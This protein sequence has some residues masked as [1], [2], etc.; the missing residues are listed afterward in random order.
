MGFI[1]FTQGLSYDCLVELLGDLI[2]GVL[3]ILAFISALWVPRGRLRP[4]LAALF[5]VLTVGAIG[6]GRFA[7]SQAAHALQKQQNNLRPRR[8]PITTGF[9]FGLIE[10]NNFTIV[11]G[12]ISRDQIAVHSFTGTP[13]TLRV[14]RDGAVLLDGDIRG[15]DGSVV[16]EIRDSRIVTPGAKCDVNSD[17]SALEIVD[18]DS[19]PVIQLFR[20]GRA[21]QFNCATYDV[22]GQGLLVCSPQVGC[23]PGPVSEIE[24]F[25]K[26]LTPIFLYPGYKHI[27]VRRPAEHV[28]TQQPPPLMPTPK[29]SP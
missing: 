13:L 26:T 21:I 5:A 23:R 24:P 18:E 28:K 2:I 4:V 17:E 1:Q 15:R 3:G 19:R 25:R 7:S 12:P 27:G 9:P 22:T 29:R 8:L 11:D 14:F 16:A 10:G 20:V 6:A